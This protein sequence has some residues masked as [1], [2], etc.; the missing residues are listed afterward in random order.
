MTRKLTLPDPHETYEARRRPDIGSRVSYPGGGAKSP[1]PYY[2][3]SQRFSEDVGNNSPMG[4]S[5]YTEDQYRYNQDRDGGD[6]WLSRDRGAPLA[7]PNTDPRPS[8]GTG[9]PRDT[10]SSDYERAVYERSSVPARP[11]MSEA[12]NRD[13]PMGPV[14]IERDAS[15]NDYPGPPERERYW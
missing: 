8:P 7:T 9:L 10:P 11:R 14:R 2:G 4:R 15:R 1:Q 3:T 5:G 13:L 12:T 6:E